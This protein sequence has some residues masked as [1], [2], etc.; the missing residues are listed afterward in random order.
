MRAV[1]I[2]VKAIARIQDV[3]F[4]LDPEFELSFA[5]ISGFFAVVRIQL[6][7]RGTWFERAKKHLQFAAESGTK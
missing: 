6:A 4:V 7:R 5:D 2:E 1:A 3:D